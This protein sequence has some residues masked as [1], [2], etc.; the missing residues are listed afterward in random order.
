MG[1]E[2]QKKDK[3]DSERV[4][5]QP[6][7][8]GSE[9]SGSSGISGRHENEPPSGSGAMEGQG[10][11]GSGEN[12][13]GMKQSAGKTQPKKQDEEKDGTLEKGL[14]KDFLNDDG[15]PESAQNSLI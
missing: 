13:P 4:A 12:G 1:Q 8:T 14:G 7:L 5:Q 6:G 3:P 9:S 11:F 2:Q 15:D 10:T